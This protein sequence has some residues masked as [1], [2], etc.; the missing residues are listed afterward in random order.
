VENVTPND[1]FLQWFMNELMAGIRKTIEETDGLLRGIPYENASLQLYFPRSPVNQSGSRKE[2]LGVKR[3]AWRRA[4][5]WQVQPS[6]SRTL[7]FGCNGCRQLNEKFECGQT[8][9]Q[10]LNAQLRYVREVGLCDWLGLHLK[11]L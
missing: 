5:K 6:A 11:F 3:G 9:S 10:R 1:K 4:D 8:K 7:G 2:G